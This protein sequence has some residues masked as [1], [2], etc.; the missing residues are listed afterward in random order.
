MR[1]TCTSFYQDIPLTQWWWKA[2]NLKY[3]PLSLREAMKQGNPLDF[4]ASRLVIDTCKGEHKLFTQLTN[5]K[6]LNLKST[7]I[8]DIPDRLHQEFGECLIPPEQ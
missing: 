6:L 3:Y 7:D 2:R 8:L 1:S 4:L 5:W